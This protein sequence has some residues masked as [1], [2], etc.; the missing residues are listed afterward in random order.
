MNS[1]RR[2]GNAWPSERAPQDVDAGDPTEPGLLGDDNFLAR[3]N[4]GSMYLEFSFES[5]T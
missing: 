1:L 4:E 2:S 5:Q 3:R